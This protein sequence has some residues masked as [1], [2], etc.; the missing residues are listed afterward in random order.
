[1]DLKKLDTVFSKFIRLRVAD[2]LGYCECFTCGDRQHWKEMDCGHYI[3]RGNLITRFSDVNCQVQC[4]KCNQLLSGNIQIFRRNLLS[5]YGHEIV[6]EL[7]RES[8]RSV[9]LMQH[10]ID[11]LVEFYK[12]K[13]KDL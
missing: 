8:K 1:M 9:H 2:D 6:L 10:E 11:D 13:I 5:K 12:Q 7:E 3:S 4:K